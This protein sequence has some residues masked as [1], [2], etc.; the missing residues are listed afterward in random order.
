LLQPL[1]PLFGDDGAPISSGAPS[2][3]YLSLP[4]EAKL[5]EFSPPSRVLGDD[6]FAH[7]PSGDAGR[8]WRRLLSESQV[9][10]HNHPVNAARAA[11]G[12]LP[13]NTLWFWGGGALPDHVRSAHRR[14][15]SDDLL[16]AALARA[17][18]IAHAELGTGL[19][20][21]PQA[22]GLLVDLRRVRD[23]AVLERDWLTPAL[24]R[25]RAREIDAIVFDGADGRRW[26]YRH[27]HRWRWWRRTRIAPA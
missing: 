26:R 18:T 4:R 11:A 12:K 7:F 9:I 27:A 2:R 14:V 8:R 20:A 22:A 10:L 1:R 5:P 3:W 16:L 6:I 23:L 21:E 25:L 15:L 13:V 19:A 17:A 24:R